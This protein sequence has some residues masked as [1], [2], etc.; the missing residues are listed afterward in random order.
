M[1]S[2]RKSSWKILIV[3]AAAN[4]LAVAAQAAPDAPHDAGNSIGCLSCH[5]M[6]S[7]YPKLLPPLG[8][9]PVDMDDTYANR[10]CRSCHDGS[11]S[12]IVLTDTHSS[13]TM[14]NKYGD[15][16]VECWV[17]HNEHL[18]EQNRYN[19][20]TYGMYIRRNINLAN[21]KKPDGTPLKA[22]TKA[23]V[24]T[25]P[26]TFADGN[27]TYNG[28]CEVCHTQTTH[29]RNDG[30]GSNQN[31]DGKQGSDCVSCHNHDTGFTGG[32]DHSAFIADDNK[33]ADP[34]VVCSGCHTNYATAPET[35]HSACA[36]CHTT[37]PTLVDS[38]FPT[39]DGQVDDD[40]T[41]MFANLAA[42]GYTFNGT[43]GRL[44]DPDGTDIAGVGGNGV[45]APVKC[46]VCHA[47]KPDAL[48]AVPA[49]H[50]GHPVTD[51][52]YSTI[53]N[54]CIDCHADGGLGTIQG[55]H[56]NTCTLCHVNPGGG[57]FARKIGDAA[58]GVD[59][60]ATLAVG[61][62]GDCLICH[63][64]ATYTKTSIHHDTA[65]AVATPTNNCTT[66]CHNTTTG[67]AGNH[68]TLVAIQNPNCQG[69]HNATAASG[70]DNVPVDSTSGNLVHDYCTSCHANP[71][72]DLIGTV[73]T[74]TA[75]ATTMNNADGTTLT[76]NGGGTCTACHTAYFDGHEHKTAHTMPT[77]A[78]CL[79][80]HTATSVPY[81]DAGDVHA[82]SGCLT[83]HSAATGALQGSAVAASG[84]ESCQGCH[85]L[86]FNGH[87][88]AHSMPTVALC[89]SCHTAT[90]APY[91]GAG[92]VHAGGSCATCHDLDATPTGSLIGSAT[93]KIG[94][95][96][97]QGCHAAYFDGHGHGGT[98]A[99]PNHTQTI[100]IDALCGNCH[101]TGKSGPDAITAP[102]IAGTEVHSAF[103]CM[104]C[105]SPVNGGPLGS[106]TN[107][108]ATWSARANGTCA[109]CHTT[110][111]SGHSHNHT[112]LATADCATCHGNNVAGSNARDA[113]TA[114]F[115]GATEVHATGCATC[116]D[117]GTGALVGSANGHAAATGCID[118][119]I[120]GTTTTWTSVHTAVLGTVQPAVDHT[121][122]VSGAA[123]CTTC[124]GNPTPAG[125][126][127]R[128]AQVTPYLVAGD[129]HAA[130]CALCHT[131]ANNGGL[132]SSGLTKAD[133]VAKGTCTT[134][135]TVTSTWTT[136]HDTATGAVT[137]VSHA[138][139]VDGLAACTTC[140]TAT[141]G[142]TAGVMPYNVADDKVHDACATC[143]QVSGALMAVNTTYGNQPI[144]KG[145]CGTCHT[146]TYFDSHVHHNT[147]KN[148][149]IY[150]STVDRSQGAN[151]A[152]NAC[153]ECHNDKTGN[154]TSFDTF[155]GIRMEHDIW[156]ATK[157]A[158]GGCTTCH[159][160]G[161]NGEKTGDPNTPLL[162]TV[163]SRI[164]TDATTSC[165]Q[166]HV[167]KLWSNATS[168]HGGHADTHFG[169]G[170]GSCESC[171]GA[172]LKAEA[173]VK[174]IH[175]NT[176]DMC[177]TTGGPYND[178][179][180]K[181][182]TNGDGDAR[183]ANGAANA[184]NPFD[185]AVYTC[186]TCHNQTQ[187]PGFHGITIAQVTSSHQLSSNSTG[188]YDCEVCHTTNVANEQL[189]THM[190]ADTVA[191]CATIC[192][193]NTT[194]SVPTGK[195]AKTVIDNVTWLVDPNTNNTR[196]EDCHAAKGDYRR[197]G[198]T[199]DSG[200]D[201]AVDVH[202]QLS[203][204]GIIGV[205]DCAN[206]HS[207]ADITARLQV[208]T[209][210][211][212][213]AANTCLTCHVGQG[214][215][216]NAQIT[217]GIAGTAVNCNDCHTA[218]GVYT[219][220]GLT[221]ADVADVHDKFGDSNRTAEKYC[222]NCHITAT[223]ANRL[224]LH[225][226]CLFCH[227]PS[228]TTYVSPT[229]TTTGTPAP[230][231]VLNG[232]STGGNT[233]QTCE[234]C[235]AV[236]ADYS[237][238]GLTADGGTDGVADVHDKMTDSTGITR[239]YTSTR[240]ILK[241]SGYDCSN[242]H[243]ISQNAETVAAW[244][245]RLQLHTW[246]VG[247]GSGDCRTCHNHAGS[248]DEILA[249][250]ESGHHV[251][252][253][254]NTVIDCENCHDSGN[255]PSGKVM[256]QYDGVR[257]HDTPYAQ[258]GDCTYCHA[259][260]RPAATTYAAGW[261]QTAVNGTNTNDSTGWA[262]DFSMTPASPIPTQLACRQCHVQPGANGA[263]L[264]IYR[265]TYQTGAVTDWGT[266]GAE[267]LLSP[268]L[269]TAG[270]NGGKV[271]QAAIHTIT[272]NS[273]GRPLTVYNY[274][275][276]LGCHSIQ[277]FHAK[278]DIGDDDVPAQNYN[279]TTQLNYDMLRFAPGRSVFN[280]FNNAFEPGGQVLNTAGGDP[281][282]IGYF[283]ANG[284]HNVTWNW[285]QVAYSNILVPVNTAANNN[286]NLV[287]TG[288]G[289]GGTG[290]ITA[291]QAR[292]PYFT[293]ITAPDV[294]TIQV[295]FAEWN[296]TSLAVY[297][298]SSKGNAGGAVTFTSNDS[299]CNGTAM[300]WNATNT[301]WE[302]SCNTYNGYTAGE[303]VTVTSTQGSG[304]S[305]MRTI[306]DNAG[307][308]AASAL[309]DSIGTAATGGPYALDV[310]A[311]DTGTNLQVAAIGTVSKTSGTGFC[312]TITNDTTSIGYTPGGG[313]AVCTFTYQAQ[314]YW[315]GTP[316][317]AASQATVTVTQTDNQPPA[318]GATS[319]TAANATEGVAYSSTVAQDA[320]DPE[321]DPIT[322]SRNAGTCGVWASVA[323]DGTISGT[324]A[325]GDAGACT[326][327]VRG[328][329][330]G[331]FDEATVNITVDA[332][333]TCL[334]EVTLL[335]AW[336]GAI[337]SNTMTYPAS[338]TISASATNS[339]S[340]VVVYG[341][342]AGVTMDLSTSTAT[343]GNSAMTLAVQSGAAAG[344]T[345]R[346]TAIFV[347]NDACIANAGASKTITVVPSTTPTA[348]QIAIAAAVYE[349]VNQTTQYIN[350]L[351]N[352]I[353]YGGANAANLNPDDN[354]GIILTA[355][356]R[357]IWGA[358]ANTTGRVFTAATGF[359]KAYSN[360]TISSGSFAA[361]YRN[362]TTATTVAG[363][364]SSFTYPADRVGTTAI[365]LNSC[366]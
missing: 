341:A 185:P 329:A 131:G 214:D 124:H 240:V 58:N 293:A 2:K 362:T 233:V 77:V 209:S 108:G 337:G 53:T 261:A 156:D 361:G 83:C 16:T 146:A 288:T 154:N 42:A 195:V 91:T 203:T 150:S 350:T 72:N 241:D 347:C 112:F 134:C 324:P 129:V 89:T 270:D 54:D 79:N 33:T 173:V 274:G 320:T 242:C 26:A 126:N 101:G 224:D 81:S 284:Q 96:D 285:A 260:P 197:H 289:T 122:R 170:T 94:G 342:E 117:A 255:G 193:K 61:R 304:G 331:G 160:Y 308:V 254:A 281:R 132:R 183:L 41:S 110:A 37:A 263:N 312:G 84:G 159:N 144:A 86:Y 111:F 188:G 196:C 244:T 292:I 135:H 169:W 332:A 125:S 330:T 275:A 353:D 182:G 4:L 314:A 253:G 65:N 142:N 317:G 336:E 180:E 139:R 237:M 205:T 76:N 6:T 333:P 172:G 59:G 153:A 116:H 358:Y 319:Y 165:T 13:L 136:I 325:V 235:H 121:G 283:K 164:A 3:A 266:G 295:T 27:A 178:T 34:A 310:L 174:D 103:D 315:T 64:G 46:G 71:S 179:S 339:R 25:G 50:G 168:N 92:Q 245:K 212:S 344:T 271:R 290:T 138:T 95:E 75:H 359:T 305:D 250:R 32:A 311:N 213:G 167:P 17:C 130:G 102:Y 360:Q 148:Q 181:L 171:H 307:P 228:N 301:R 175:G 57:N 51:W 68:N 229:P 202:N 227:D 55:V 327:I 113:I 93:G 326:V 309:N 276:C 66:A 80:C 338:G 299:S 87:G 45:F 152:A 231:V 272:N 258:A 48:A 62:A 363:D 200:T 220:H 256:Y 158:T 14:G 238:H 74:P 348:G 141:A 5:Q 318:F 162:A 73:T 222:G 143:H 8:G 278:P 166:C 230:T 216:A 147:P 97:C 219:L 155:D 88:H 335:N 128:D 123:A 247:S 248:A 364:G 265:N 104:T 249:G 69:C 246:T 218:K 30:S 43:T 211:V 279:V 217:A 60:D 38:A 206:C 140:H 187:V 106:A 163:V 321:S 268:N 208:H 23:V 251:G 346:N 31:H 109:T 349:G 20:S 356:D 226:N 52:D 191:N 18:Q 323:A 149:L 133:T 177:H 36:A 343:Y 340:L 273:T 10:V 44:N 35:A 234:N 262:T 280:L 298:T 11:G 232:R 282:G 118:C 210:P 29:F 225:V 24:F 12:S 236:K 70:G 365:G 297:A 223:A 82:G 201:G 105:H 355:G 161:T 189:S 257:H 366:N 302:G 322:Y 114:P 7:T 119:H 176:C 306:V 137:G 47:A 204:S 90:A 98:A 207:M 351:G 345:F 286:N 85:T 316:Y 198:L 199:D 334:A 277:I 294:D 269:V 352:G 120:D 127:A 39:A 287:F 15:W 221:E 313:S 107:W 354:G 9:T 239:S 267:N 67:H 296:G 194:A 78:L 300:T 186:T 40:G 21:I 252:G 63:P 100:A 157:D 259:D 357:F 190:P 291:T 192:H 215:P 56:S 328:T 115:V 19:G 28:I 99:T 243:D 264:V 151:L 22:G 1:Q 145:D 49:E 184:A 303:F